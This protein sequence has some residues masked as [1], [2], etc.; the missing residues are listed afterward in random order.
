MY[1]HALRKK[2][3]LELTPSEIFETKTKIYKNA[4]L[5]IIGLI[6]II[7]ALILQPE[8]AGLAGFVYFLIGPAFSVFFP[9]SRQAKK[10]IIWCKRIIMLTLCFGNKLNK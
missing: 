4:I 7:V 5:I 10:K 3:E 2:K 6:S 9:L 8:K 1:V